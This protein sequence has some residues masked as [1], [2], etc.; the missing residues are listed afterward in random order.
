MKSLTRIRRPPQLLVTQVL[1]CGDSI[2]RV[3]SSLPSLL[4]F[5]H[6]DKQ[7]G[8][9]LA[10]WLANSPLAA[11]AHAYA[12][13]VEDKYR[14]FISHSARSRICDLVWPYGVYKVNSPAF[15]SH[16]SACG[17]TCVVRRWSF[18]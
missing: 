15:Y 5:P 11:H 6:H 13:M 10:S 3:M 4:P 9:S 18:V 16:S 14:V 17:Y 7:H 12:Y 1:A 8:D 2:C